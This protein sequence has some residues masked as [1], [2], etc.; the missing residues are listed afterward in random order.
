LTNT[1]SRKHH[2]KR[3]QQGAVL[4]EWIIVASAFCLLLGCMFAIRLYCSLQLQRL[5]D[6][7]EDAWAQAMNGC[8][9][10]SINIK[11]LGEEIRKGDAPGLAGQMIPSG[12]DA[13]RTFEVDPAFPAGF[14]TLH[15]RREIKF[16]C[17]PMPGKTVPTS[18]L[19]GWLKEW[20]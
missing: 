17:N 4:V 7:R 1:H 8:G 11:D 5:D 12:R 9:A 15:G 14:G 19:V 6:A 18:D 13:S 10:A 20:L 3:K 16:I 2:K